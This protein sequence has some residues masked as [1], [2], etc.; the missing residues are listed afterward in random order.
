[1]TPALFDYKLFFE[2]PIAGDREIGITPLESREQP[3]GFVDGKGYEWVPI[4]TED[5]T[6]KRQKF[7]I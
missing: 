1:M 3:L 6:L 4:I 7:E 2:L 5:G